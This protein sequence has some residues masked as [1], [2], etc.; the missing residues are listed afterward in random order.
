MTST[1]DSNIFIYA[2]I[3][4]LCAEK[5]EKI[6]KDNMFNLVLR[7]VSEETRP[8]LIRLSTIFCILKSEV[9]KT[10]NAVN[11]ID[12]QLY[13][14][15]YEEYP[16]IYKSIRKYIIKN[17]IDTK[18]KT[19]KF[20]DVLDS[21]IDDI[22]Y[23]VKLISN[24]KIIYPLTEQEFEKIK[25]SN[26]FKKCVEDLKEIIKRNDMD[27]VHLGLCDYFLTKNLKHQDKMVFITIDKD[28]FIKHGNKAKIEKIIKNLRIDVLPELDVENIILKH[29]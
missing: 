20:L 12:S 7:S 11:L 15:F 29:S 1:L 26:L 3:S 2:V 17:K 23:L 21:I 5:V 27:R 16:Q 13:S 28:D 25:N 14:T 24:Q 9:I 22:K 18:K 8:Q 10:N 4:K 6:Y 19:T